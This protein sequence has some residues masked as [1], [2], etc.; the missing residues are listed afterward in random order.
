[1]PLAASYASKSAF[2][3]AAPQHVPFTAYCLR[4]IIPKPTSG[5]WIVRL[6]YWRLWEML[7]PGFPGFRFKDGHSHGPSPSI[8]KN[9]EKILLKGEVGLDGGHGIRPSIGESV[10]NEFVSRGA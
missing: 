9:G 2:A 4:Q 5:R 7:R 3:E 1:M 8:V 10:G 6:E